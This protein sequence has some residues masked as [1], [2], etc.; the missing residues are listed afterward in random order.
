[1]HK[2]LPKPTSS[3]SR[4]C[5]GLTVWGADLGWTEGVS[6]RP[7]SPGSGRVEQTD[8]MDG[9]SP[10]SAGPHLGGWALEAEPLSLLECCV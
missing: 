6:L 9:E 2:P 1:M 4:F 8:T 7:R 10:F 3:L 5:Q